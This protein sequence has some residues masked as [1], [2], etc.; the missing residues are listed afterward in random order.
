[1]TKPTENDPINQGLRRAFTSARFT[2]DGQG[3]VLRGPDA[4]TTPETGPAETDAAPMPLGKS[5]AGARGPVP[6]D[7]VAAIN[8]AIHR[9]RAGRS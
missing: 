2:V 6:T 1:M 8:Q 4:E 7:P 5:D 3:R 9:A